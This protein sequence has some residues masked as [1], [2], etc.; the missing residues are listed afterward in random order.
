MSLQTNTASLTAL[1]ESVNALPDKIDTSGTATAADIYEG[2]TATV[3]DTK[4]TGTNPYNAANVDPAVTS[5][6]A[7]IAEKGVDTTGAGLADIATL[8]AAIEAGGGEGKTN[9][10]LIRMNEEQR[11]NSTTPAVFEHG[12][13]SVPDF[14]ILFDRGGASAANQF[15]AAV[16]AKPSSSYYMSGVLTSGSSSTINS[17]IPS[18]AKNWI[19]SGKCTVDETNVYIYA[20]T[21]DKIIARYAYVYLITGAFA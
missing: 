6:L 7:A 16:Y 2:K 14:F 21:T 12:L 8:V 15:I 1:L 19:N 11:M 5:A 13:G 10:L 18:T 3:N 9:K 17:L 20:D 4:L